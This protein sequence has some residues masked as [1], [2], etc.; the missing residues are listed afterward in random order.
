MNNS[1]N[2]VV[3]VI[4]WDGIFINPFG[5]V[6]TKI[7]KNGLAHSF[8]LEDEKKPTSVCNIESFKDLRKSE[9]HKRD[10]FGFILNTT[11]EQSQ[12][13]FLSMYQRFHSYNTRSCWYQKHDHNCT[14]AIQQAIKD[15][16]IN[17]YFAKSWI[18]HLQLQGN[19]PQT[20]LPAYVQE[21]LL[22]TRNHGQWLVKDIVKYTKGEPKGVLIDR[23]T[24]HV[25]SKTV[26]NNILRDQDDLNPFTFYRDNAEVE[27]QIKHPKQNV[28]DLLFG[29]AAI[30]SEN[31][32]FAVNEAHAGVSVPI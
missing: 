12:K 20:I 1:S 27:A 3:E 8:S 30:H 28:V 23:T 15:A 7:M 10:G 22:K 29:L 2:I 13:I 11:L 25:A 9:Q 17:L 26:M 24:Q 32:W 18:S 6:T 21:G 19:R 14:Y 5:H 4:V 31:G 16:G